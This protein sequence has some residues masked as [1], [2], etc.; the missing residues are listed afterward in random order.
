MKDMTRKTHNTHRIPTAPV[1]TP[2]TV[3]GSAVN[4]RHATA[5]HTGYT[6]AT[7]PRTLSTP[8]LSGARLVDG[9]CYHCPDG[10]E[11][12]FLTSGTTLYAR[13]TARGVSTVGDCGAVSGILP[14]EGGVIVLRGTEPPLRY[15]SAD[16]S[17]WTLSP[18]RPDLPQVA[19]VRRDMGVETVTVT[20][21]RLGKTYDSR[22]S[23]LTTD[24]ATLL[25]DTLRDAYTHIADSAAA[26]GRYVQPVVARCLMIGAGGRVLYTT[27]PVLVGPAEG[28][29]CAPFDISFRSGSD[30]VGPVT[31]GAASF[32]LEAVADGGPVL[33]ACGVERVQVVVSPQLHPLDSEGTVAW[34][35]LGTDTGS[36][37]YRLAL[38]GHSP[39]VEPGSEGSLEAARIAA[40]IGADVS[41]LRPVHL[42]VRS[43]REDLAEWHRLA[44][45][46]SQA[47]PRLL[48]LTP[49]HRFAAACAATNGDAI[50]YG[51]VTEIP[52]D[53]YGLPELTVSCKGADGTGRPSAI[54]VTMDDGSRVVRS[55][56]CTG[57]IPT[58]LSPLLVYPSPAAR[59]MLI[60]TPQG[61]T[62]ISLAPSHCGRWAYSIA[63]GLRPR[64]LP[65]GGGMFVVPAA[66]PART[67]R[68]NTL[69]LAHATTPFTP[70]AA[71]GSEAGAVTALT[72]APRAGTA[73][74][75]TRA[76]FYVMGRQGIAAVSAGSGLTTLSSAM[77]DHRAVGSPRLVAMTPE[78]V[79]ALAGSDLV[80]LSGTRVST[81]LTGCQADLMAYSPRMRELWLVS[82]IY[83]AS[84]RPMG[85]SIKVMETDR[86][87]L[88]TRTGP[89]PEAF[90]TGTSG[91]YLQDSSGQLYDASTENDL[92]VAIGFEARVRVPPTGGWQ[93]VPLRIPLTGRGISGTI[94]VQA[95][96]ADD[97]WTPRTVA[98]LTLSG[99]LTRPP[100]AMI[101][102]PVCH[103]LVV[104]ASLTVNTPSQLHYDT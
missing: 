94:T 98:T 40:A 74:G 77:L 5:P 69:L 44:A 4:L 58:G 35:Y 63:P 14:V 82:H 2:V 92:P 19:V 84:G 46:T 8:G 45:V 53:G 67:R 9:A 73:L 7:T 102:V 43:V 89:V 86:R 24:D 21:I 54:A 30:S 28:I 49:P 104:K 71:I 48:P 23:A 61:R 13:N 64:P 96:Q 76:S 99:H 29:Q 26:A 56:T 59:T 36:I 12:L 85:A 3:E 88:Y 39:D 15:D 55:S 38:R 68:P 27:P 103:T 90:A 87:T 62:E 72:A 16:G 34:R 95:S 81:L 70:R 101:A 100:V 78:G 57:F 91:L 80:R 42:T 47:D 22:D 51:D 93:R 18:L 11:T 97:S 79:T 32:R 17:A 50:L 37:H 66:T 52:F 41:Q 6:P 20:D 33:A 25:G 65:E 31:I 83:Q 10:S 60:I 1:M 75:Y